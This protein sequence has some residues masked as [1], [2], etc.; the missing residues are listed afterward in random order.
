VWG[1][2]RGRDRDDGATATP[3]LYAGSDPDRPVDP[4]NPAASLDAVLAE[5]ST[6][7]QHGEC[8]RVEDYLHRLDPSQRVELVFREFC[9]AERAGLNPSPDDYLA[10]FPDQRE[11]LGRLFR[12]HDAL[13]SSRL[14][15][16]W[17]RP[18]S[19][20]PPL[21]AVGDEVGPYRLIRQL[22]QGGFARVFLAEQTDLED[23]LVV[24][25]VSNRVTPEP[26]LLARATHPHIVEV[27]WHGLI[28]GGLLQVICMPFLG[29]ATLSAVLASRRRRGGRPVSGRDLLDD[30]DRASAPGYPSP[31]SGRPARET[32]AAQSYPRAVVWV[33]ARL[34]EALDH[35]YSRG[36]L[37]G[38][39][40]PSNI[41]L[42][43][44]GNPMLLDFNLAAGWQPHG[45]GPGAK[46]VPP[47]SGGTLAYMA[48]ERLLAVAGAEQS[49]PPTVADR[50]RADIFS[51]GAVL[52]EMLTGR[53]PETPGERGA[54]LRAQASDHASIRREWGTSALC[55]TPSPLPPGLR[56]I[57]TRCLSP[58]PADRY[59]RASELAEDLDRW[60]TDRMLA[61]ARDPV[62]PLT[63]MRW[64]RRQ[65][66]VVAAAATGLAVAL[67]C[68]T[69]AWRVVAV[70]S[71]EHAA[72][73]Y[74]Q[75][76][77]SD[78]SGAFLVRQPG[79][80]R[81]KGRTDPAEVARRHLEH[82]GILGAKDGDW[83]QADEFRHLPDPDREELEAWLLEQAL[84]YAH[85]LGGRPSARSDWQRA[86]YCL[87]R[88]GL[89]T[90]PGPLRSEAL[91]LRRRLGLPDPAPPG[92]PGATV[93][94]RTPGWVGDYLLGVAAELR[95]DLEAAGGRYEAVLNVR[96]R[97]FWAN[98]RA[99]SVAFA[100]A[101]RESA[102]AATEPTEPA[103]RAAGSRAAGLYE[104]ASRFLS[105]CVD[106]RPGNPILHRQL[107][108]CYYGEGE[109]QGTVLE[110]GKALSLDPDHAETYLF[111]S[112]LR[113]RLGQDQAALGDVA[114]YESLTGRRSGRAGLAAQIPVP[115]DLAGDPFDARHGPEAEPPASPPDP[116]ESV[117]RR[118][119]AL[120]LFR[121]G[122]NQM[123][124]DE[125]GRVL[126]LNPDDL[127]SRYYRAWLNDR[128]HGDDPNGDMAFLVAHPL[129][130]TWV[131]QFPPA[132]QA[133]HR[134]ATALLR[135]GQ[136]GPSV[137][138]ATT[139]LDLSDQTGFGRFE[140]RMVLARALAEA[141]ASDP[142]LR[143]EA[144]ERLYQAHALDP[145][146]FPVCYQN[147]PSLA[148]IRAELGA[149]P[150]GGLPP[151][152]APSPEL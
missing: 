2:V 43:A 22:G 29:G 53:S 96:P 101:V 99:A 57:L 41:L 83:R 10:R 137:R 92:E 39:V 8:P 147:E 37:H 11:P 21:P 91:G 47:D 58:D 66:L 134:T 70:V 111:R 82:Y 143:R 35:A 125:F 93:T 61:F 14:L 45:R 51:L 68:T 150:F 120:E 1:R 9:L 142:S 49:P 48:P 124:L 38:D 117:T 138:V 17:D 128:L 74:S 135:D 18:A 131:R 116:D 73:L 60:R 34:A 85:T 19:D 84:R 112:I 79:T 64:A 89:S 110:F 26:R 146:R 115:L 40:K 118:T 56:A 52:L 6:R 75:I 108:G 144:V 106:Q 76:V 63:L 123:A 113:V 30:L 16:L 86:L 94:A 114:R 55:S 119:L 5:F 133:F 25:K 107:A 132:I 32:I 88:T 23:R 77:E 139:A 67:A 103:R 71:R 127:K 31:A 42:T 129:V 152:L 141:S 78:Q 95:D 65:R 44:D 12:F 145:V 102:R 100:R 151:Y 81:V 97:S 20:S 62:A 109:F 46:E 3:S 4:P 149:D 50:H 28:E 33:V 105:V 104:L 7:W 122:R 87:D 136:A 59:R 13:D 126:D 24:V 98:Y 15:G 72:R 27:L 36:V 54:S 140:S 121:A 80:G 90:R 148:T 130:G 69:V